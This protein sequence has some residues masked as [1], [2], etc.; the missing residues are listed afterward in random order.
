MVGKGPGGQYAVRA[1][2]RRQQ[3]QQA[4]VVGRG[5]AGIGEQG[6]GG[7]GAGDEL[8]GMQGHGDGRRF[9]RQAFEMFLEQAQQVVGLPAGLGQGHGQPRGGPGVAAAFVL[10]Q[11][12]DGAGRRLRGA[13]PSH[14]LLD[15]APG[16][17]QDG[18][19][20]LEAGDRFQARGK[21]ERRADPIE[22]FG[23][24]AAGLV[25]HVRQG[26][27][28]ALLQAG[29]RQPHQ[30]GEGTAAYAVEPGLVRP[31]RRQQQTG[32]GGHPA[33]QPIQPQDAARAGRGPRR[34]Q[35]GAM[36]GRR[37]AD[38][39][40]AAQ[41]FQRAPDAPAQRQGAA[42]DTQAGVDVEQQAGVGTKGDFRRV[43]QHGQRGGIEQL[44]L[45]LDIPLDE[46]GVRGKRAGAFLAHAR[47]HAQLRGGRGHGHHRLVFEDHQRAGRVIRPG[48]AQCVE[49]GVRQ[50]DADPQAHGKTRKRRESNP[51]PEPRAKAR[52]APAGSCRG[53][54]RGA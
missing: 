43:L 5:A 2:P 18:G 25:E 31:R 48:R 47:P 45:A 21:P 12:D 23:R 46:R 3:L 39:G 32:Q 36:G 41:L 9:Q 42:E 13:Q 54:G 27:A 7:R 15:E 28:A 33:Q 8:V 44:P 51:R 24:L 38:A 1:Q 53:R 35:P 17:D 37:H 14:E 11:E 19:G 22:Q 30:G 49:A 4:V 34:Q 40:P 50:V 6:L 29:A 20:V 16:H 52:G 26:V 10:Q